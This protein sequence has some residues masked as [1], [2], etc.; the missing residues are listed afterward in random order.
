[1]INENLNI[2]QN[3]KLKK[4]EMQISK[5]FGIGS[6]HEFKE[7]N[8]PKSQLSASEEF[9]LFEK[10]SKLLSEH[11]VYENMISDLISKFGY[12]ENLYFSVDNFYDAEI[13][14]LIEETFSTIKN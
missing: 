10:I 6:I 4:I 1:M 2:K 7:D 13:E 9:N 8:F 12:P 3:K 5:F 11:K 14:S